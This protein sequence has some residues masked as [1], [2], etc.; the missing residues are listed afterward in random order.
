MSRRGGSRLRGGHYR[1]I[2]KD[3][4]DK[5]SW[6][7]LKDFCIDYG[8]QTP[9]L[10]DVDKRNGIGILEYNSRKDMEEALECLDD[11]KLRPGKGNHFDYDSKR[12]RV[13]EDKDRDGRNRGGW[14]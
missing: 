13:V 10:A 1:L 3:I 2:V 11:R 8:A 5:A 14:P 4:P 6:Q 12:V 9:V 7:D